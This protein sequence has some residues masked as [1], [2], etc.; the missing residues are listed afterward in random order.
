M[1]IGAIKPEQIKAAFARMEAQMQH[2]Q[3]ALTQEQAKSADLK[4]IIDK[5]NVPNSDSG[6]IVGAIRRGHMEDIA[7]TRTSRPLA[8]SSHGVEP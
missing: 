5:K 8:A 2:M 3:A 1:N 7:P 4:D 6:G